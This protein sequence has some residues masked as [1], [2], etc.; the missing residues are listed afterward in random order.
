M[1]NDDID[2]VGKEAM[3]KMKTCELRY[4]P[5]EFRRSDWVGDVGVPVDD[6]LKLFLKKDPDHAF[7]EMLEIVLDGREAGVGVDAGKTGTPQRAQEILS[8]VLFIPATVV[9]DGYVEDSA[10]KEVADT[11]SIVS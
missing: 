5:I 7:C 2:A 1:G 8:W 6:P 11:G 3:R 9:V 4:V 10:N